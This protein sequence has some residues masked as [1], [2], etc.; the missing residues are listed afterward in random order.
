[1]HT[2]ARDVS[3]GTTVVVTTDVAVAKVVAV[4][5][6]TRVAVVAEVATVV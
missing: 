4:D 2:R 5:V 1:M 6:D 3:W